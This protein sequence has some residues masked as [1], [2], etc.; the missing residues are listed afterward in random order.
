M[1]KEAYVSFEV[2]QLLKEKGFNE[3]CYRYYD[4]KGDICGKFINPD[5]PFNY[6]LAPYYLCPSQS[7]GMKWLRKKDIRICLDYSDVDGKWFTMIGTK[8]KRTYSGYY[9]TYEEAVEAAILYSLK[10]LI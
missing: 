1:V 8:K 5:I 10:N 7:M 4:D 2:A 6:S 3:P 9:D